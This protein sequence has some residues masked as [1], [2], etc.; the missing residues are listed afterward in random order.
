MKAK[1]GVFGLVACAA[2][3]GETL[4]R[5]QGLTAYRGEPE[6]NTARAHAGGVVVGDR[7]MVFGGV[8]DGRALDSVEVYE[9]GGWRQLEL[10]MPTPRSLHATAVLDGRVY[11]IGGK[12]NWST[13][14]VDVFDPSSNTWGVAAPMPQAR[15]GHTAVVAAGQIWV[16]GGTDGQLSYSTALVYSPDQDRWDE[17]EGPSNLEGPGINGVYVERVVEPDV[18]ERLLFVFGGHDDSDSRCRPIG[19]SMEC[20]ALKSGAVYDLDKGIWRVLPL[21]PSPLFEAAMVE[22]EGV[23]YFFGGYESRVR[24]RALSFDLGSF[25]WSKLEAL[26]QARA[27]AMALVFEDRLWVLGGYSKGAQRSAISA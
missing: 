2:C 5:S 18:T 12:H 15:H 3:G 16:I 13:D 1:I 19:G 17:V 22:H 11:L 25:K 27:G 7:M 20:G 24:S 21:A 26:P 8:Q 9:P 6:L 4:E 23:A 10:R 14:Q